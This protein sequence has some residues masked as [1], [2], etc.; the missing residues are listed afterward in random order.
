M[1]VGGVC[2]IVSEST[3]LTANLSISF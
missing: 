2:R 1:C 3:G